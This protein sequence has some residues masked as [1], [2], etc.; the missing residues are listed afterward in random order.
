MKFLTGFIGPVHNHMCIIKPDFKRRHKKN[1][2]DGRNCRK[3]RD[4]E[5]QWTPIQTTN[6]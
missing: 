1:E 5:I 3:R 4:R 2:F 6:L